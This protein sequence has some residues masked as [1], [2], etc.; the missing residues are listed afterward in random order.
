MRLRGAHAI[1]TGA[2]SG[3]GEG[4]ARLL[5]EQGAR[6]SLFDLA[7]SGGAALADELGEMAN[8]T[9]VDVTREQSLSRGFDAAMSWAGHLDL[10]VNCAGVS[11]SIRLLDRDGEMFP[12]AEF[13]TAIEVN[14]IGLFDVA[15]RSAQEM[16]RNQ[17]GA[18]GERGLIVNVA[19]ISAYEGMIGQTAYSASKGG[20]IALT[21]P[22]ARE[23]AEHGIR[24]L[25]VAP[26]M[27]DTTMLRDLDQS[28]RERLVRNHVFPKRLGTPSEFAELVRALAE[29]R[30]LNGEVIRLD[31]GARLPP[32]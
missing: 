9:A 8:F 18:D 1:V 22:L 13:R 7:D 31:A 26:G 3:L 29:I 16:A 21:V 11:P 32:R 10:S 2:A 23:L 5:I 30:L 4:T 15:R 14:L 6:V 24:V 28:V 27:M 25:T 20:V 17:P 12:I 19:S